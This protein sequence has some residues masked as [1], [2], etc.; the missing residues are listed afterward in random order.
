MIGDEIIGMT[1]RAVRGIDV[2]DKTIA[3]DAY[4][5]RTGRKPLTD[6]HTR[7]WMRKEHFIPKLS[8]RQLRAQW[9]EV[10]SPSLEGEG[11]GQSRRSWHRTS[12]S[13]SPG[14]LTSRCDGHSRS[15]GVSPALIVPVAVSAYNLFPAPP[16]F[17]RPACSPS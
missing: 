6:P 15:S 14:T 17:A 2:S 3:L 8:N 4:G 12:P 9:E 7:E 13:E 10:G 11:S 16:L 1:M 5:G